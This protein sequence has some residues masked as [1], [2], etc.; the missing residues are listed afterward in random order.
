ME[1]D[2]IHKQWPFHSIA[3]TIDDEDEEAM[4][5]Q[6]AIDREKLLQVVSMARADLAN[7]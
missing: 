3:G 5:E 2:D 6:K 7:K 1:L 4:P